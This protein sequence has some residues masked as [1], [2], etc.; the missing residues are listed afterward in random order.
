MTIALLQAARLVR[1]AN[2]TF[3]FRWHP[4]VKDEVLRECFECI[5]HGLG[6]PSM[7]NDPILIANAMNRSSSMS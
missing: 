4:K 2:P 3:S 7:R 6:Y 5:R 1:V